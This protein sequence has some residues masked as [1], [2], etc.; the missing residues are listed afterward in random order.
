MGLAYRLRKQQRVVAAFTGDGAASQ[1][2][3][4]EALNLA[5]VW[6][7]PVLFCLE[8]NAYALSTPTS[9]QSL[10]ED[11]ATRAAGYGIPGVVVDG[12]DV[13]AVRAAVGEAARRAR[14]GEGPTLLEFKTFRM[15]GH[16]E[17][18][19]TAYVPAEL[20]AA[21]AE[22]D[23]LARFEPAVSPAARDRIRQ[24]VDER[25]EAALA[26]ALK[27]PVAVLDAR[28]GAGRSIRGAPRRGGARRRRARAALPGRRPGRDAGSAA[29]PARAPDGPG[30]RRLRRG[31]Q[32][33]PG[34]PGGVRPRARAQH[35]AHRVRR[36]GRRPGSGAQGV[37]A[38]RGDAV[39]RLHQLRL[40]PAREQPGHDALPLGGRRLR[41]GARAGRRRHRGGALPLPERGGVLHEHRGAE[42]RGAQ[43]SARPKGLLLAASADGNPVLFLEHKLLYRSLKGPVPAG[44]YTVPLGRAAVVR[45]G[46]EATIVTYGVGVRWA[47][48][49]AEGLDVEVLDLRTLVPWDRETV[50]ASVRKTSRLLVVHEAALSGGFGAEVAAWVGQHAFEWL[51]APVMRVGSLDTPIPFARELEAVHTGRRELARAL[52]TLLTY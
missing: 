34:V 11:L 46:R 47:L 9:D 24:E 6:R 43:H 15:R 51:D 26:T 30:H 31:L 10:V 22:R 20:T 4:H 1:G 48:E 38:D 49:A 44:T 52:E 2:D 14:A 8:N 13:V 41:G 27:A 45:E 37:R 33:Y 25:I 28:A 50:L 16:E 40:Q 7:L 36:G 29:R 12:N 5:A 17:A 32:G 39:R 23:P 42:D 21:W 35:A 19:G 18:S 3:F